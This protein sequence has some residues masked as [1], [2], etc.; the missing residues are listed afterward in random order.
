MVKLNYQ[1]GKH[2]VVL[3]IQIEVEHSEYQKQKGRECS[4]ISDNLTDNDNS[5]SDNL[6]D[7]SHNHQQEVM[8][9]T[10]GDSKKGKQ[11]REIETSNSQSREQMY[12]M[13]QKGKKEEEIE[14]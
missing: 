4:D 5:Q 14:E 10:F 1:E 7:H 3:D 13:F 6:S 12:A 2:K 8:S 11:N 9:P